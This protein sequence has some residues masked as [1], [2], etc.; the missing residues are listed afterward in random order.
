MY[1]AIMSSFFVFWQQG[2]FIAYRHFL[3]VLKSIIVKLKIFLALISRFKCSSV[4]SF[5]PQGSKADRVTTQKNCCTSV[6][7]EIIKASSVQNL[8]TEY[9]LEDKPILP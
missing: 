5:L 4:Q 6:F 1:V 3:Y 7:L 2:P 9:M 8:V